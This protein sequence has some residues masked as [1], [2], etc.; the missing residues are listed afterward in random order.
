MSDALVPDSEHRGLMARLPSRLRDFAALARLDRPIGWWLLFWPCAWGVLL[1]GPTAS[2]DG[3]GFGLL[4]WLLAGAIAMRGAGCVYNDIVDADLDARVARTAAR[5]VAS[6]RV[7]K[8]AAWA[9]LAVLCLVGLLVLLQLRPLA[10]VVALA[11]LGLVALYPFMKRWTGFPQAWLGLVFTWGV[12]TGWIAMRADHLEVIGALYA[13][14][15]LWCVGYDTIYALQDREDDALVG[16]GSSALT[17]GRHVRA[18]VAGFYAGAVALWALAFW[19]LTMQPLALLALVPVAVHL[20]WQVLTLD[21]T[22]GANALARFRANRSAGLLM[23]LACR[24]IG[25][26]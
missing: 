23:A 5:P 20:G 15:V 13:G 11:S 17:L 26:G 16:I 12:P 25:S 9:W 21:P 2:G 14:A 7:S 1:A 19:W 18:G 6:G 10:Q 8:R 4:L 22:D 24:S 3:R